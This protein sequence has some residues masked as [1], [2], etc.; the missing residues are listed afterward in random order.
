ME[1][2]INVLV[3]NGLGF[4]SFIAL[5]YF[6]I[7]ALKDIKETNEEIAKTLVSIQLT[8][9]SLSTRIDT[10]ENNMKG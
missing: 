5:I 9:T 1:N 7:Y 6:Y 4:A 3:N 2:I 8:L 10:L